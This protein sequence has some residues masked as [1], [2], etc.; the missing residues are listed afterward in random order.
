[1]LTLAPQSGD[2]YASLQIGGCGLLDLWTQRKKEEVMRCTHGLN[3]YSYSQTRSLGMLM[4]GSQRCSQRDQ[5]LI[6]P[7]YRIT[8]H[9]HSPVQD[10]KWRRLLLR[11]QSFLV[12]DP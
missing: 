2:R 3:D 7:P 12:T 6:I 10:S 11:F 4:S 5:E 1:M 8:E 9:P